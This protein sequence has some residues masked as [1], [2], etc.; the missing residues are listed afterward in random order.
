M[1]AWR[2]KLKEHFPNNEY[3]R[4]RDIERKGHSNK[5]IRILSQQFFNEMEKHIF[6]QGDLTQY[7]RGRM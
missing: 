3:E 5:G 2:K 7:G 4:D 6:L 1:H